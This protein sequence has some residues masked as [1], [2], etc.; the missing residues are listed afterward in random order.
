MS[1][2][3]LTP[4]IFQ[5]SRDWI[6]YRATGRWRAMRSE[7]EQMTVGKEKSI[8][9][10]HFRDI[11]GDQENASGNT[12]QKEEKKEVFTKVGIECW[13]CRSGNQ[14]WTEVGSFSTADSDKQIANDATVSSSRQQLSNVVTLEKH[15]N[16]P[17]C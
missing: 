14:T 1:R 3:L 11:P 5:I 12:K 8:V 17:R 2:G 6:D 10:I 9:E 4:A 15:Q 13:R 7:K 16:Q